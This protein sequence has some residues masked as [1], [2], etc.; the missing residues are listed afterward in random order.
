MAKTGD[1]A[2]C[3]FNLEEFKHEYVRFKKLV[4]KFIRSE[5]A[6]KK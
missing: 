5:Q 1:I 4:A 3:R 6:V 2:G